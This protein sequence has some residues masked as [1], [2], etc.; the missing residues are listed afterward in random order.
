M[1][2]DY[3]A[4][5]KITARDKYPLP[6][7][8]EILDRMSGAKI[9][10]NLDATSGYYQIGIAEGDKPKTAF[11]WKGGF[12]EFN[13]IPFGF[14]NA[15]ATFQRAMDS[16]VGNI[17]PVF[18]M[19]Y[20]D[21]IIVFSKNEEDHIVHL[22]AVAKKLKEVGFVL[23]KKKCNFFKDEIKILGNIVSKGYFKSDPSKIDSI[24][25]Y[26]FPN[27]IK[28]LR[29]FLGLLNHCREY[30]K[31]YLE[32]TRPLFD[33][34][35]GETK[36]SNRR[37]VW[38]ENLNDKFTRIKQALSEEIKRKQP[39]FSRELILTTDASNFGIGAVLAQR[40]VKNQ[41]EIIS[42]FSKSFD[43]CQMNYSVTD[44][45]LLGVIKG[46][47]NY[48]HYLLGKEFV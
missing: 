10:S 45:E 1:C 29:S 16:L 38:S 6:R 11:T 15:P 26:P 3:R 32:L 19:P 46:I 22:S 12:Y 37:L 40:N 43:K 8:D 23:N 48:R 30:V 34:L 31:S 35:K 28:E 42:L 2:I 18:V 21:D 25:N 14:C 24:K 41:E 9:F 7:I 5:N 20:L 27:N 47:E 13:R 36:N 33:E 44:K 39:D 4:L 17:F